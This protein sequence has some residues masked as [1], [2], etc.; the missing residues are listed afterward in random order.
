VSSNGTV[1]VY[2]L[3]LCVER[4]TSGLQGV[5]LH[6]IVKTYRPVNDAG[7]MQ[8]DAVVAVN[9]LKAAAAEQPLNC[10]QIAS[11]CGDL[12]SAC[13]AG[14]AD[15]CLAANTGAYDVLMSV[16]HADDSSACIPVVLPALS[17]LLDG[18]PDVLEVRGATCVVNV[19]RDSVAVD[20]IIAA[21]K[22]IRRCCIL[23]EANR[24]QFVALHII[25]A[26]A[27]LL[28]T[29]H[30]HRE[31]VQAACAVFSAL[32]LDDDVR[33]Q[34]GK[35]HEHAKAIVFEGNA[36]DMLLQL[37]SGRVLIIIKLTV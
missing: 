23:H 30:S 8:H 5:N 25:P 34:F 18:Q 14:L 32:T 9:K 12:I 28:T 3:V 4:H 27:G 13:D 26:T 33:V 20:S 36:L 22:L 11:A 29:H 15:R 21:L 31:L 24:Q 7:V 2:R 6:T 19:L 10:S 37:A 17:S 16:L 35:S 1:D